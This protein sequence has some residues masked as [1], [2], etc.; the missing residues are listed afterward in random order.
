MSKQ[1][2]PLARR[3][4]ELEISAE[5]LAAIV[6]RPV[7]LVEAWI[8]TGPD[9]EALVLLRFLDDPEDAARR[10]SQL[11]RTHTTTLEGDG[12][13][14][15]GIAAPPYGSGDIGKKTGGAPA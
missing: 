14:Y 2:S 6:R 4:A 9:T 5:E 13:R 15:A 7:E 8:N 12:A 11:R 3:L 10:V 1:T